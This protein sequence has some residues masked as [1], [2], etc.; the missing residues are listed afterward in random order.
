[1]SS[2]RLTKA[3]RRKIFERAKGRCEYCLSPA[4]YA[5]HP[6]EADHIVPRSKG[7]STSLENLALSCGCHRFKA[8]HTYARDPKTGRLVRLFNPRTQMDKTFSLERRLVPDHRH[9][10]YRS[11]NGKCFEIEPSRVD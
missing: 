8:A 3:L 11:G 6:F 5:L 9:N 1:M 10:R 7:G 4:K 2:E